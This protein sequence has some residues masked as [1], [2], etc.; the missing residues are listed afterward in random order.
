ML[1]GQ[2][3]GWHQNGH[4]PVVFHRLEGRPHRHFRFA[5]AD[6]AAD[7]SVHRFT[8]LH[9]VGD[10]LDRFELIRRFFVFERRLELVVQRA[11]ESIGSVA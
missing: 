8:G 3:G 6:V 1:M 10:V 11:V 4:L 9:V 7:Q 2:Q 5:V